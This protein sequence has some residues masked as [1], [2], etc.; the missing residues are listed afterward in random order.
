VTGGTLSRFYGWHVAILPALS[1]ALLGLHLL[2]V[3]LHGM[4]RPPAL[5]AEARTPRAMSFFPHFA[6]REL[7][8]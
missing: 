3:Q 6:L 8:V 7:L 5:Q 1:T 4:S 2:L